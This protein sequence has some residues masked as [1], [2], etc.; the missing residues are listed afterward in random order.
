MPRRGQATLSAGCSAIVKANSDGSTCTSVRGWEVLYLRT[1][2]VCA[3]SFE[4]SLIILGKSA[5]MCGKSAVLHALLNHLLTDGIS[6]IFVPM[7][8]WPA[9][10]YFML[11][12]AACVGSSRVAMP[13]CSARSITRSI[14]SAEKSGV[15]LT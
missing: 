5:A 13:S 11:A 2:I 15:L 9:A 14:S 1:A 4:P 3:R 10:P 12:R 6:S 8:T 7:A